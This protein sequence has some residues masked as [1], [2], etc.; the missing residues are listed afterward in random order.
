MYSLLIRSLLDISSSSPPQPQNMLE[1]PLT[2]LAKKVI[3]DYNPQQIFG[4]KKRLKEKAPA[5]LSFSLPV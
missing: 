1:N 5:L 4:L 3:L 2:Y